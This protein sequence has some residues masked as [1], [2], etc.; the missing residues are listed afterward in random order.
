MLSLVKRWLSRKKTGEAYDAEAA[1][2]LDGWLTPIQV[3]G[4][5]QQYPAGQRAS[6]KGVL[7][8]SLDDYLELLGWTARALLAEQGGAIPGGLPAILERLGR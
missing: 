8:M 2:R 3:E 6:D 1:S 4:D 7:S 5:G